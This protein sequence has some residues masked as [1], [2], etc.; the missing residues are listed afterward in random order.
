M[1]EAFIDSW[2]LQEFQRVFKDSLEFQYCFQNIL[3]FIIFHPFPQK[4]E[5]V[6]SETQFVKESKEG[7]SKEKCKGPSE[8]RHQKGEF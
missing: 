1:Q 6:A 3:H 7:E 5:H 8:F 4:L 2:D